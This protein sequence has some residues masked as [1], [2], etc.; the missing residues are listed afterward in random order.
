MRDE[1]MGGLV[2]PVGPGKGLILR[3]TV[4][5][6]SSEP[7]P[8][9]LFPMPLQQRASCSEA[10]SQVDGPGFSGSIIYPSEMPAVVGSTNILCTPKRKYI[11]I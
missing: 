9:S 8:P 5:S 2:G 3:K 4:A 10:T 11:Y 7:Q 6:S 1:S